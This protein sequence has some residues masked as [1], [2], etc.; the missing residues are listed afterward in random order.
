[1]NTVG[2]IRCRKFVS[3]W[4]KIRIAPRALHLFFVFVFLA[5]IATR[6]LSANRSSRL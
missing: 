5:A 1:M 6:F 3:L 4:A 2:E